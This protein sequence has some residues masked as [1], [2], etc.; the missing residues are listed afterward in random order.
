MLIMRLTSV[1]LGHSKVMIVLQ[2]TFIFGGNDFRNK[3]YDTQAFFK[4]W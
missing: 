2:S 3:S 4:V 1:T